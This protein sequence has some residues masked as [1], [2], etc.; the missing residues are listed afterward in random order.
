M[1]APKSCK[2]HVTLGHIDFG[3]KRVIEHENKELNIKE[4][5]CLQSTC[6]FQLTQEWEHYGPVH[7]MIFLGGM[8]DKIYG[9]VVV[10][11]YAS[12]IR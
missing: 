11:L 3:V 10:S 5:E 12:S 4:V 2:M 7:L 6:H 9:T 8:E 1:A